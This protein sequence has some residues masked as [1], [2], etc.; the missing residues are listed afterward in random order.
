MPFLF[1]N[2]DDRT[3]GEANQMDVPLGRY[4]S[5]EV[6]ESQH[7]NMFGNLYQWSEQGAQDRQK[8]GSVLSKEEANDK[9]GL[10]NLKFTQPEYEGTAAL[11]HSRKQDELDREATLSLG[12]RSLMSARGL[13]GMATS[14]VAGMMNPLDF[15]SMFVPFVGESKA[16]T[17]LGRGMVD[18]SVFGGSKIAESVFHGATWQGMA[19]IPEVM[20]KLSDNTPITL[21]DIGRDILTQGTI[22]GG[23]HYAMHAYGILQASTR[24]FMANKAVND[25]MRGDEIK[26]GDIAKI[27]PNVVEQKKKFEGDDN[28]ESVNA[29]RQLQLSEFIEK[30][31]D[32]ADQTRENKTSQTPTETNP[33]PTEVTQEHKE[34][35]TNDVSEHNSSLKEELGDLTQSE[36]EFH[37]HVQEAAKN[38]LGPK[39]LLLSMHADEQWP[40]GV[41]GRDVGV[42]GEIKEEESTTKKGTTI[43][44]GVNSGDVTGVTRNW[45]SDIPKIGDRLNLKVGKDSVPVQVS[46]VRSV[47][48]LIQKYIA[49]KM[50]RI[51]AVRAAMAELAVHS[52]VS[53][54][55]MMRL[56]REGKEITMDSHQ[57]VFSKD[58]KEPTRGG[59]YEM[60][61]QNY[62]RT[63]EKGLPTFDEY[64]KGDEEWQEQKIRLDNLEERANELIERNERYKRYQSSRYVR[65]DDSG[66]NTD[67]RTIDQEKAG[68]EHPSAGYEHTV[69][70]LRNK[71]KVEKQKLTQLEKIL[72]EEHKIMTGKSDVNIVESAVNCI[73]KGTNV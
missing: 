27:D 61:N 5:T 22:S 21:G 24:D 11:L 35:D 45:G 30:Q 1:S 7:N 12:S 66:A 33:D 13:G 60:P 57:V 26:V 20:R 3:T 59:L 16:P 31:R 39:N 47:R 25:F 15:G 71:W 29:E 42:G 53:H 70:E 28:P 23:L 49:Q 18:R 56:W 4:L 68:E 36:Q 63:T 69:D 54:E 43:L 73:L 8:E 62:L 40:R 65:P 72:R 32:L 41:K 14:M 6:D 34:Y 17:M 9:Y 38:P 51:H 50:D 52:G 44:A 48:E 64:K 67:R 58:I 10:P 37:S 55:G 19:E 46:E 2:I